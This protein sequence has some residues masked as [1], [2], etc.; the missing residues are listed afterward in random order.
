MQRKLLPNW[1]KSKASPNGMQI[2]IFTL[3]QT[4]LLPL[5]SVGVDISSDG[6]VLREMWSVMWVFDFAVF[7]VFHVVV[8][9]IILLSS[10]LN[11]VLSNP[12]SSLLI[13]A[14]TTVLMKTRELERKDVPVPL[15]EH[16]SWNLFMSYV[17][18]QASFLDFNML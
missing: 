17:Q 5:V 9:S 4:I 10:M 15:G 6:A 16:N 2:N 8:S 11:L 13:N 12:W 18:Q 1:M 7:T 14:R 3:I